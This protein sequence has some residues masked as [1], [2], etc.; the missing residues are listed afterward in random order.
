MHLGSS[1]PHGDLYS[2]YGHAAAENNDIV[3][4]SRSTPNPDPHPHLLITGTEQPALRF[5]G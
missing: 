1:D 2:A 4:R 3:A 5:T